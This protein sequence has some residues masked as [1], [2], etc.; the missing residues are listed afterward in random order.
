MR[1]QRPGTEASELR[2]LLARQVIV[3][4]A[5]LF[6]GLGHRYASYINQQG[7]DKHTPEWNTH[8]ATSLF[9]SG[10]GASVGV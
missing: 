6:H 2:L 4:T 8:Q 9:A 1:R 5:L 7:T 3:V 10:K